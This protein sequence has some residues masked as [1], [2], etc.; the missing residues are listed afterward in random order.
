MSTGLASAG[1][2][3]SFL[4]LV[5]WTPLTS[6]VSNLT[7]TVCYLLD[8]GHQLL[9]SPFPAWVPPCQCGHT[10][11][12]TTGSSH[13]VV[14][15]HLA[16]VSEVKTLGTTQKLVY[17]TPFWEGWRITFLELWTNSDSLLLAKKNKIKI[18][19]LFETQLPLHE[20][21]RCLGEESIPR[22]DNWVIDFFSRV[23]RHGWRELHGKLCKT[24][25]KACN[26]KN[27]LRFCPMDCSPEFSC[28]GQR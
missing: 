14:L 25:S 4:L 12:L 21:F 3:D 10:H 28:S 7:S 26:L 15:C 18:E 27:Y 17:L 2:Y 16:C 23:A 22:E 5:V 20:K 13:L 9:S 8:Q 6:L 1:G 24:T 19:S 11:T